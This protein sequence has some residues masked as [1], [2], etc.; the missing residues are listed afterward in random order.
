MCAVLG[1]CVSCAQKAISSF[2]APAGVRDEKFGVLKSENEVLK[3]SSA[4][5]KETSSKA[6]SRAR[7][8]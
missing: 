1:A 7:E 4:F 5:E 2:Q 6:E 8:L 3:A